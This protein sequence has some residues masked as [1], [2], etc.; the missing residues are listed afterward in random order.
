[1]SSGAKKTGTFKIP[2]VGSVGGQT[3]QELRSAQRGP[4]IQQS[5]IL[6]TASSELDQSSLYDDDV[7][8]N[9][10]IAV[11]QNDQD[12]DSYLQ[13]FIAKE[14]LNIRETLQSMGQKFALLQSS[15]DNL[16]SSVHALLNAPG[17]DTPKIVAEFLREY[18]R[19]EMS[20]SDPW[21]EE[22]RDLDHGFM[23]W[24]EE[25]KKRVPAIKGIQTSKLDKKILR[26][27]LQSER[28]Q[29]GVLIRQEFSKNSDWIPEDSPK[30]PSLMDSSNQKASSSTSKDELIQW[31]VYF[32]EYSQV[33]DLDLN[34]VLY[35]VMN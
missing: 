2:T 35:F 3:R 25:Q 28:A 33:S 24:F 13:S 6:T 23:V 17:Q 9:P 5:P 4:S 1:M 10:S 20:S 7:S 21:A 11:G 31:R 27:K 8:S 15:V 19:K 12:P 30:P 18:F 32:E 29:L 16:S 22:D 26:K 14:F 34:Y